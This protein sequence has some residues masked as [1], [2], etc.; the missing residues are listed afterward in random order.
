MLFRL[1]DDVPAAVS[2]DTRNGTHSG[3]N[4]AAG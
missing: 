2:A 3:A 1:D 4:D